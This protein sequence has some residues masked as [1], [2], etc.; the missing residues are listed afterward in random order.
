[1]WAVPKVNYYRKQKA[2][3]TW[4]AAIGVAKYY[5]CQRN[6]MCSIP[7]ILKIIS[8]AIRNN[9]QINDRVNT[10]AFKNNN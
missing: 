1:M 10:G 3:A 2:K 4:S 5:L 7:Q 8:T 6:K 9:S